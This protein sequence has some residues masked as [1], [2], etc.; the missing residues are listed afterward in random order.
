[1]PSEVFRPRAARGG[2]LTGALLLCRAE[3]VA[4]APVAQFLRERMVVVGAGDGWSALVPE[5]EPWSRDGEPVDRVLGGW[6]AALAVAGAWPVLALWWE[7]DH[8]G[9]TLASGFRR[10]VGYEWLANGTPLG[11]DEAM[12]TFATRLGLD[13]VL[14]VHAL[15]K[16][17]KTDVD[18]DARRRLLALLAVLARAGVSLP[19][20]LTP[21]EPADRLHAVAR[22][23][24]EAERTDTGRDGPERAGAERIGIEPASPERA[25]PERAGPERVGTGQT[26]PE[27]TAP[28]LNPT[29]PHGTDQADSYPYSYRPVP[30]QPA[31]RPAPP[32]DPPGPAA[33]PRCRRSPL[34]RLP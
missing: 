13:P 29:E 31:T 8:S 12:R 23:L 34:S 5:D 19:D 24:A 15:D 27:Q 7:P 2:V 32:R 6:A 1:M 4:V 16:L 28:E 17:A 33:V 11:E 3:P 21:G 25:G 22:V 26:A 9:Y 18:V 20:G 30:Q 14:D 10:P